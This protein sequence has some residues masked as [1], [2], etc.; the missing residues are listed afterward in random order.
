VRRK[1]LFL[2]AGICPPL[3]GRGG[4]AYVFGI[5]R[6]NR[7][8]SNDLRWAPEIAARYEKY[9]NTLINQTTQYYLLQIKPCG[10]CVSGFYK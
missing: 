3:R 8:E 1:R 5:P 10:G 4:V 6:W 7:P 2:F 9:D